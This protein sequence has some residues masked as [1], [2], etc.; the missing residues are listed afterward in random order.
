MENREKY[1]NV[2]KNAYD[3]LKK[4]GFINISIIGKTK[5]DG[6]FAC[7][8]SSKKALKLLKESLEGIEEDIEA[9]KDC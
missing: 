1:S 9:E 3:V 2:V 5:K 4:A 8:T 6:V 7:H